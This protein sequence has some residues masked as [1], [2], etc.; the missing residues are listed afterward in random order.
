MSYNNYETSYTS[1]GG[2][3]GGGGGGF[4]AEGSQTSPSGG[5]RDYTQDSLR[6]VTI[7]QILGGQPDGDEFKIDSNKVSQLTFVGQ[8]R[9]IASQTTHI[10]YKLDDGTGS[11]EVKQWNDTDAVVQN[12]SKARLVEGMYCRAWGKV[13]GFHDRKFVAA[14]ILRPIDDN[15]EISYHMLEAT[16]VHLFFSRGP[17][18]NQGAT[19]QVAT[20][21]AAQQTSAGAF[22]AADLAGYSAH[23][24]KVYKYLRDAPQSNEGLHQQDIAAKIGLDT[25]DV[26]RAGDDLLEGGLIYTTVDDQTWAILETD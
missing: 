5:R 26:A 18:N 17:I 6:P 21:G 23:A 2:G 7:K 9:N 22:G 11:I 25:A 1:Y 10:T 8:I 14:Q 3:G 12:P 4:M 15:N 20:K 16:A 13:K 24:R 19:G